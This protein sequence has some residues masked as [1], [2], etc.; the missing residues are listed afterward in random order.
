MA[1]ATIDQSMV[2]KFH[3]TEANRRKFG[4]DK[5]IQCVS[6]VCETNPLLSIQ[7]ASLDKFKDRL[8]ASQFDER[9]VLQLEITAEKADE[10]IEQKRRQR[11]RTAFD[12]HVRSEEPEEETKEALIEPEPEHVYSDVEETDEPTQ[13]FAAMSLLDSIVESRR[14]LDV[15][16]TSMMLVRIPVPTINPQERLLK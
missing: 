13:A 9:R 14:G 12:E 16:V 6:M 7:D 2:F 10:L 4:G 15:V 8:D 1:D 5:L 3:V 11:R